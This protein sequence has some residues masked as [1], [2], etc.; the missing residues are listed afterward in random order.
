[1]KIYTFLIFLAL[2]ILGSSCK[3]VEG[4]VDTS[5][6]FVKVTV[7]RFDQ[8]YHT[9]TASNF[10]ALK[11]KYAAF[12][13]E[14]KS[15]SL[16]LSYAKDSLWLALHKQVET[17]FPDFKREEQQLTNL[18][19]HVKY[20]Y[21]SF[22]TPRIVTFISSLDFDYQVIFSNDI[23]I[24]SL[25]TFLGE[26]S[27]F[28]ANYPKYLRKSFQPNQLPIQVARVIAKQ[29][30]PKVP[31]RLFIERMIAMG[32]IQY[33]I[34]QFLPEITEA[35]LFRY[36]KE[37]TSWL[38]ANEEEIWK[39]FIDKEYLYSTDKELV[40]RFLE[41]A[42]FSKFYM[43]FDNE[44]PGRVGEW[45]G[46]KIVKSYMKNNA[47]SLPEMMATPPSKIFKNSKYKPTR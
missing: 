1:M 2:L 7:D 12:F 47:V 15:D 36:T 16:W 19:K 9:A 28:Y 34:S 14:E 18:F 22:K 43:T 5:H 42:P 10:K 46:Y 39:Y 33:A 11:K 17:V 21:P 35:N 37:K 45:V 41:N 24:L 6:V 13:P 25:D 20:Y 32:Q 23:I 31:Y 40:R 44:T 26:E 29:T 30:K 3:D 27:I 8:D 38:Q 4:V